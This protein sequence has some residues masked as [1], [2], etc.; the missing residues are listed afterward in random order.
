LALSS[1][2]W[3]PLGDQH[4]ALELHDDRA[5]LIAPDRLHRDEPLGRTRLRLTLA[6]HDGLGIERVAANTGAGILIS[7]QPRFATAF[8]LT[9]LTLMPTIRPR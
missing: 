2:L 5:I 6:E 3:P 8:W 7:F 4:G 9:S 1:T